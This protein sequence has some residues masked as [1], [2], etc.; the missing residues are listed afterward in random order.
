MCRCDRGQRRLVTE[1]VAGT[2]GVSVHCVRVAVTLVHGALGPRCGGGV[3]DDSRG[4]AGRR[5]VTELV[6]GQRVQKGDS[7]R[8]WLLDAAA[9]GYRN[10][11]IRV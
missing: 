6:A 9:E 7:G 1:R 11:W 10:S 5:V 8:G 3:S 4:H 2:L